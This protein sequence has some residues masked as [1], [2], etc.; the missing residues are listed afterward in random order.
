MY[1][2]WWEQN[3]T[4]KLWKTSQLKRPCKT[5]FFAFFVHILIN[6][7]LISKQT[8]CNLSLLSNSEK[9]SIFYRFGRVILILQKVENIIQRLRNLSKPNLASIN[10]TE[11][12]YS[13]TITFNKLKQNRN[14]FLRLFRL[15]EKARQLRRRK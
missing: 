4:Q 7:Y 5:F 1:P 15:K 10:F 2:L 12:N 11:V 8:N 6:L 14:H 3:K 9:N 13:L